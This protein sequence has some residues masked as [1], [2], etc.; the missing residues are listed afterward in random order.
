MGFHAAAM[1][2]ARQLAAE[3]RARGQGPRPEM[4]ADTWTNRQQLPATPRAS[5]PADELK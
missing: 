2:E 1:R 4:A 5:D 3:L